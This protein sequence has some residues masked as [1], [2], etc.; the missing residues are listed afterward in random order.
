MKIRVWAGVAAL[1][2]VA[3]TVAAQAPKPVKLGVV[4]PFTGPS[5][6]FGKPMLQGVQLAVEQ[7]N[8]VGG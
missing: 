2:M 4:G 6:D 3:G 7:F 8:A 5:S 1:C